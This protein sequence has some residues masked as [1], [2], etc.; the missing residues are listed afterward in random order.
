MFFNVIG[1]TAAALEI[2][3]API[4]AD[5]VPATNLYP[6]LHLQYFDMHPSGV[7]FA[8]WVKQEIFQLEL[9]A[10]FGKHF[11]WSPEATPG[12]ITEL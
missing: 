8:L 10:H 3:P 9:V 7:L 5:P 6:E 4:M 1:K 11:P 2:P 12:L